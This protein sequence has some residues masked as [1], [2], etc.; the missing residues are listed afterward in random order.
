MFGLLKPNTSW[1]IRKIFCLMSVFS[2]PVLLFDKATSGGL[3]G[4]EG[5]S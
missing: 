4:Q 1:I 2:A 3:T 5:G